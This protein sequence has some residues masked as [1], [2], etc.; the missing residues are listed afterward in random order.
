MSLLGKF[1]MVD[2]GD[3]FQT[4]EVTQVLGDDEYFLLRQ[5][6]PKDGPGCETVVALADVAGSCFVFDTRDRLETFVTWM[7]TPEG[8][9]KASLHVVPLKRDGE[10]E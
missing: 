6:Y 7:L 1:V 9:S 5:D 10:Q 4:G 8:K 3:S 2:F